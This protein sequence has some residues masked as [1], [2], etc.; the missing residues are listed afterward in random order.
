MIDLAFVLAALALLIVLAYRGVTLL[1]A[2][3]A[4][5]LLA[6]LLTGGLPILGAYTQI[7][8]T[9]TGSFIIA[10]FPLFMLGAACCTEAT[11]ARDRPSRAGDQATR[12]EFGRPRPS[13]RLRTATPMATSVACA[14][15]EWKRSASPRTPF[16]RAIWLST[17][18]RVLYPLLR[19]QAIRPFSA[20]VWM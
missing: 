13:M 1:I 17:P 7:F 4:A 18:A 19:C 9:N 16:Q 12:T 8:M 14:A 5:A 3:P 11:R 6:A 2:A 20:M 15:S 10:F